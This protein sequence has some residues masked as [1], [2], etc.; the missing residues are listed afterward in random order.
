[1]SKVEP[2]PQGASIRHL[3]P[4]GWFL[5]SDAAKQV[6]KSKDTLVRWRKGVEPTF[7]PSGYMTV[8]KLTIYLYSPKDIEELR[9]IAKTMKPG[10]K[11]LN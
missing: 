11:P 4:D 3:V 2:I 7:T 9:E 10:R 1:M 8:G 6:G 5:V